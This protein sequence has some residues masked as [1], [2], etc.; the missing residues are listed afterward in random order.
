MPQALALIAASHAAAAAAAAVA[1]SSS[2]ASGRLLT[3]GVEK[4]LPTIIY[5]SRT[6]GQLAQVIKELRNTSYR[7]AGAGLHGI[8]CGGWGA[9]E[10]VW[11]LGCMGSGAWLR[12][13]GSVAGAEV[14][15]CKC[16]G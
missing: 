13:M 5:S 16:G 12:Y 8:R 15:E 3:G 4:H 6:H 14:H 11:G 1:A 10:Q 9:W 7:C 2:D